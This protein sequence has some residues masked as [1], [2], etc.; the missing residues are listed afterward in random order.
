MDGDWLWT[1]YRLPA[2]K[3]LAVTKFSLSNLKQ[4]GGWIIEDQRMIGASN[5][6]ISCSTLYSVNYVNGK[7]QIEAIYEFD[8]N[9]YISSHH[10][11]IIEWPANGHSLIQSLHMDSNEEKLSIFENGSIYSV[12]VSKRLLVL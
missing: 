6:F 11:Q 3:K 4:A 7:H 5:S 1:I 12:F 8:S 2:E 10:Q 9:Q